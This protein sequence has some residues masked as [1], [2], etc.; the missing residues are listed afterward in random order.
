MIL[1]AALYLGYQ[2]ELKADPIVF[3]D[4]QFDAIKQALIE[5]KQLVK[6]YWSDASEAEAGLASGETVATIGR[7][8]FQV[9]L[10]K[11]DIPV[12]LVSPKEGTQGWSTSTCVAAKT[13][14]VD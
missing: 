3:T 4:E 5:Q 12:K 14:N 7:I 10:E 13:K 1:I 2:E 9:D 6:R 8:L 11:E